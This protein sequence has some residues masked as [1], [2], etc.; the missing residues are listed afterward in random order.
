MLPSETRFGSAWQFPSHI[1]REYRQT[2]SHHSAFVGVI[3]IFNAMKT[4]N[5]LLS[6][7]ESEIVNAE[8]VHVIDGHLLFHIESDQVAAFA[9]GMWIRY[10]E[11]E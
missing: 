8:R 3:I 9:P 2:N 6:N 11:A 10:Y 7:R 5:V 1:V 4:Y